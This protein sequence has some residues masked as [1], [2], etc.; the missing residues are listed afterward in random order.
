MSSPPLLPTQDPNPSCVFHKCDAVPLSKNNNSNIEKSC[1]CCS[2]SIA[3]FSETRL[4]PTH[5]WAGWFGLVE[6]SA[7]WPKGFITSARAKS[8]ARFMHLI[9]SFRGLTNLP[10]YV[11]AGIDLFALSLNVKRN[12]FLFPIFPCTC[13]MV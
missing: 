3:D 2:A 4:Y 13:T 1:N 10:R 5:V 8:S 9:I 12:F 6:T 7:P 11:R